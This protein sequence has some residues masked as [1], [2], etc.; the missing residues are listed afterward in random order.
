MHAKFAQTAANASASSPRLMTQRLGAARELQCH[1]VGRLAKSPS[2]RTRG[3]IFLD[4]EYWYAALVRFQL[5]LLPEGPVGP[6]PAV[7]LRI[8]DCV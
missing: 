6:P 3:I 7:G 5:A 2:Y 1:L 8:S 4:G